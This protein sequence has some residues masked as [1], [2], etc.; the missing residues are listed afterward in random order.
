MTVQ[1]YAERRIERTVERMQMGS[2]QGSTGFRASRGPYLLCH[3]RPMAEVLAAR[4]KDIA[5]AFANGFEGMTRE[6]VAFED[7]LASRTAI[8]EAMVGNMPEKHRR[9]LISFEAGEPDWSLLE[10]KNV[11]KLP[12]VK[13]RMQ[14]LDAITKNKRI[15]L[16]TKLG[17]VLKHEVP[18]AQYTLFADKQPARRAGRRRKGVKAV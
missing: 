18:E 6:P 8:V 17:E 13:W 3:K 14:N 16:V 15:A 7:L 4:P 10:V 1:P 12:A 9:F 2:P 11:R 5:D